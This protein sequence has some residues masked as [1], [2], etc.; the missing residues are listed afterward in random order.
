[1]LLL[2]ALGFPRDE[3]VS[4]MIERVLVRVTDLDARDYVRLL[5]IQGD[6]S[7]EDEPKCLC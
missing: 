2:S 7:K 5:D 6:H 4:R 3:E 1:V